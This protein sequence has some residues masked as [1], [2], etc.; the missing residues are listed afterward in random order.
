MRG[1]AGRSGSCNSLRSGSGTPGPRLADWQRTSGLWD[2]AGEHRSRTTRR[3][4]IA[5]PF[6]SVLT[7]W[8]NSAGWPTVVAS[9]VVAGT[10]LALWLRSWELRT[11]TARG[12]ALWL[13]VE[14]F[15]RFMA[16]SFPHLSGETTDDNQLE[17][18]TAW[19]V[20]VGEES[21]WQQAVTASMA[22]PAATGAVRRST[23]PAR[24]G[25]A[26]AVGLIAAA[27]VS[28]NTPLLQ[29]LQRH[30]RLRR[31]GRRRRRWWRRRFMVTFGRPTM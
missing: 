14:S 23:A 3:I 28:G 1:G 6:G 25:P 12:A 24:Y 22:A 17:L 20:A 15:R 31:R 29:R 10:G 11:R 7:V 5:A 4:G 19:A 8:M 27:A 13:Q 9:A 2:P 30:R 21:S 26:M 18:Y 16:D